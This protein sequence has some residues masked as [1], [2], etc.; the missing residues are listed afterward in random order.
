[1][2]RNI[3][4]SKMLFLPICILVLFVI[5]EFP[6]LENI[7]TAEAE[8]RIGRPATPTSVAGV[9][10]RTTRRHVRRHHHHRIG[11]RVTIL[12]AGCTTVITDEITYH[13]CSGYYYRPYYEGDTVVYVIVEAP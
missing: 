1:M 5:A 10:R 6:V 4:Q 2:K 12:P 7:F 9:A 3:S 11:H 13:H 8:A